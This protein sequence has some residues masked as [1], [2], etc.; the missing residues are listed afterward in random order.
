MDRFLDEH[1]V[2]DVD[3]GAGRHA[4]QPLT[5]LAV[6]ISR[7]TNNHPKRAVPLRNSSI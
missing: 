1:G 7:P 5:I 6:T 3:V 4:D 2:L